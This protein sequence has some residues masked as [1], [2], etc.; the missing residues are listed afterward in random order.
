LDPN[1][2]RFTATCEVEVTDVLTTLDVESDG[3]WYAYLVDEGTGV[4]NKCPSSGQSAQCGAIDYSSPQGTF[5]GVAA[6]VLEQYDNYRLKY[7]HAWD[8]RPNSW[9]GGKKECIGWGAGEDGDYLTHSG[10]DAKLAAANKLGM[11]YCSIALGSPATGPVQYPNQVSTA[12]NMGSSRPPHRW[13]VE[14]GD[15]F[16]WFQN[17]NNQDGTGAPQ[18]HVPLV[19]FKICI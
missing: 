3:Y 18:G 7:A 8:H 15:V 11:R 5:T 12:T 4:I 10:T 14:P 19:G 2:E 17:S 16:R 13:R 9:P 6:D 1:A